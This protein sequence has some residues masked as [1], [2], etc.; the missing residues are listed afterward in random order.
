MRILTL[1]RE[2]GRTGVIHQSGQYFELNDQEPWGT[3]RRPRV[4]GSRSIEHIDE[5]ELMSACLQIAAVHNTDDAQELL[6]LVSRALG[7]NRT[8]QLIRESLVPVIEECI[9]KIAEMAEKTS[10]QN[11]PAPAVSENLLVR[12]GYEPGRLPSERWIFF[13]NQALPKVTKAGAIN[14]LTALINHFAREPGVSDGVRKAMS[15]DLEQL[16][17]FQGMG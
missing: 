5:S 13:V 9:R 16:Q 12:L 10:L 17:R 1:L 2:S 3:K 11:N 15:V 7:F 14:M 6:R 4:A 8:G